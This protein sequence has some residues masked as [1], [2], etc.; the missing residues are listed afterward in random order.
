MLPKDIVVIPAEY[1]ETSVIC[2]NFDSMLFSET[3][4]ELQ[5]HMANLCDSY[6]WADKKRSD[7]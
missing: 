6:M 1:L 4:F 3:C 5:D 7:L 2:V